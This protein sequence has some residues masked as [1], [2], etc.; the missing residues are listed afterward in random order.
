MFELRQNNSLLTAQS[1]YALL[2]RW[3]DAG[4]LDPSENLGYAQGS[5]L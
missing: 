4:T 5:L 2:K 3:R 1:A